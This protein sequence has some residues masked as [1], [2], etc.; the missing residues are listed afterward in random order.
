MVHALIATKA[1]ASLDLLLQH[2]ANPNAMTLSQ[3]EE[4]K[5]TPGYLA[6]CM[7]WLPGLQ[8]LVEAGA[9]LAISRGAGLKN[10]TALHVAAEHCHTTVVEYIVS[11]TTAKYH[12]QVDSMGKKEKR[13]KKKKKK[14]KNDTHLF[15]IRRQGSSLCFS[16]R[17]HR[18]GF[19]SDPDMSIASRS[20][21][22]S[23]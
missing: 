5:V 14:K 10:K 11:L 22:Y 20:S 3:V 8:A 13:K 18:F 2:G 12:L 21:G 6:A 19:L 1:A 7:G 4:D 9:D 15:H 17:A 23:R 16:F